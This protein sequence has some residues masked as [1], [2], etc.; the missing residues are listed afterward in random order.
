MATP[1]TSVRELARRLLLVEAA[2]TTATDEHEAERVCEKLRISL[3][4]FAGAN[5][6]TALMRRSLALSRAEV[7]AL[8]TVKLKADGCM[9]G[10]RDLTVATGDGNEAGAALTAHFL[11][12]L[13]TFVG[14]PVALRLVR[15]AWP[16]L[17]IDQ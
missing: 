5:G 3:T 17:T 12:L 4:R 6:F 2:I 16:D 1:S 8:E 9:E 7:P 13:V 15:D 10:F 14:E 11:W